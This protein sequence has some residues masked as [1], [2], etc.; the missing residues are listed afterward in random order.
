M[1]NYGLL[2]MNFISF[3]IEEKNA[4]IKFVKTIYY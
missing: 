2:V 3:I 1:M 4:K